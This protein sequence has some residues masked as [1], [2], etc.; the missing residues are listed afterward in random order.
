MEYGIGIEFALINGSLSAAA[1]RTETGRSD[2]KTA[3]P[4]AVDFSNP[5]SSL[6]P[7]GGP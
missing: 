5:Q 2:K 6:R 7:E 3:P 4:N 1:Q